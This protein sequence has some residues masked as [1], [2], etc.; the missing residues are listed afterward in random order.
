MKI[1][2]L[3]DNNRKL[4]V[5]AVVALIVVVPLGYSV[6]SAFISADGRSGEPFLEM[7]DATKYKKC[8]RDTDYMRFRHFDL[9]KE[10]R[11]EYVRDGNQGE[12]SLKNC[13]ECHPRRDRFCDQCHGMVNLSLNCFECHY[14]P[15]EGEKANH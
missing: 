12:V 13:R 14:Y 3:A 2:L 15:V 6:V 4:I 7:P 8:V 10:M 5:F 11:E 1:D 9:L